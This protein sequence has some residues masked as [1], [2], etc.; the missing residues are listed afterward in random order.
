IRLIGAK[1][2]ES[3]EVLF[4]IDEASALSS[5]PAIEEAIVRGRS[6]GVRLLL[7]YQSDAQVRAAFRDKPTL[8][9]DNCDAQIYLGANSYETAERVSKMIGDQS[10]EVDSASESDSRSWQTAGAG[11]N[12]QSNRNWSR[13][14]AEQSR[15]LMKPEEILSMNTDYL[16]DF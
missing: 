3:N 4:L 12:S 9:Y 1:G 11:E 16:I 5:L 7:A 2:S 10:I 15:P 6:A 8:I 14:W 13:N